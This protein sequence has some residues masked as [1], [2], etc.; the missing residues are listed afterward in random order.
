MDDNLPKLGDLEREVMQL[1]WANGPVTAEAVREHDRSRHELRGLVAG[2]AE[3][4]ALVAGALLGVL[5]TFGFFRVHALG[6]VRGLRGQV[7]VDEQLVGVEDV[8]TIH[9]TDAADGV[10]D[11]FLDVDH[12]TDRL[13]AD[14]RDG[15]FAADDDDV[16]LH[17]GFASNA[18]LWVDGQAGVEN[19]VRNGIG[20]F[21]GMAFA[22]GFG[23]NFCKM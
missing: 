11:D 17:E 4:D 20:N 9:V 7:V 6:D 23:R 2:V 19:G 14:F 1:V 18:A 21:V 10:A 15:D 3:H 16:A 8:V 5:F 22:D 12:G 13:V